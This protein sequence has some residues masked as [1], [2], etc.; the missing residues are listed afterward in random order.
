MIELALL[1][2]SEI[3][4]SNESFSSIVTPIS[5]SDSVYCQGRSLLCYVS[6]PERLQ[7]LKLPTLA[8]RRIRG[9]MIELFK[10]LTGK[11]DPEVSNF[12]QLKG[13]S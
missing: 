7:K 8:Y 10:I 9:D 1:T 6:Y 2:F 4:L 5:F 3:C 13:K 11:Y 12:I